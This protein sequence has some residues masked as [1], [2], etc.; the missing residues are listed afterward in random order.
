MATTLPPGKT[1]FLDASGVPLAGGSVYH[2]VP[3]TSTLKDTY[4]DIAGTILNT[5]PVTLD[6]AGE[7][8]IMG[9]GSY[10]QVVFDS[11][12]NQMW[13]QV[14][15]CQDTSA[16]LPLTGGTLTGTLL[17]PSIGDTGGQLLVITPTSDTLSTYASLS[18]QGTTNQAAARE[19][20]AAIGLTSNQGSAASSGNGDKAALFVGMAT[21]AGTGPGWA[22]RTSFT[23]GAAAGAQNAIGHEI[24]LNNNTANLGETLGAPGLVAPVA[25]GLTITGT[26]S[27][28]STAAVAITGP[29]T[30]IW[31]RG[32][33]LTANS[34]TQ[35]GIQDL[36]SDT[37]SYEMQGSHAYGIDANSA[38][39]SGA[40][41]RVGNGQTIVGRNAA[42]AADYPILQTNSS[43]QLIFGGSGFAM[44]AAGH[45]APSAA[46]TYTSGAASFPWSVVYTASIISA[47]LQSSTSY[48]N[49]TA[50]AAGGVALGQFY[51]N[52]SAV[53]IR[54]T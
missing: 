30:S 23:M 37:I 17:A 29:G 6:A 26:G 35:A 3:G 38:T 34:V 54:I 10:R 5:N 22:I 25:Y 53:Q 2:Y 28:R 12:G 16:C 32:V 13:D 44:F 9:I 50:A 11:L 45:F 8:V 36:G 15:Q 41:I 24:D 40:M 39:F 49:D 51:R 31:N 21:G 4:Q 43:N 7:A 42:N 1:Q 48:A 27:Y 52:G 14:T 20:L 19:F 33:V 47:V 46:T 18:V